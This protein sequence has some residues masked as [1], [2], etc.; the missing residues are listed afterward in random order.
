MLALAHPLALA[1]A[2][3]AAPVA[4]RAAAPSM[5]AKSKKKSKQ[6]VFKGG[7]TIADLESLSVALNPTG[8]LA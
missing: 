3:A 5:A 4:L 2:G 6:P 8:E 7:E 1:Y